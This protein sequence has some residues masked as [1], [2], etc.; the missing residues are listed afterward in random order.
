MILLEEIIRS[1]ELYQNKLLLNKFPENI[2]KIKNCK[3]NNDIH[4][5]SELLII[6]LNE[7]FKFFII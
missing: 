4:E 3:N 7:I 2:P 5:I 1:I 6:N